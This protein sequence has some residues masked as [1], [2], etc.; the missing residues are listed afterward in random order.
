MAWETISVIKSKQWLIVIFMRN[1]ACFIFIVFV[2]LVSCKKPKDT[3]HPIEYHCLIESFRLVQSNNSPLCEVI[4]NTRGE[5]QL[6][7][8]GLVKYY[9]TFIDGGF[10]EVYESL[11]GDEKKL[12]KK[13]EYKN[14]RINLIRRFGSEPVFGSAQRGVYEFSQ[15]VFHYND[16][17]QPLAIDFLFRSYPEEEFIIQTRY[18]FEYDENGN[19]IYERLLGFN[20]SKQWVTHHARHSY[21]KYPNNMKYLNLLLFASVTFDA[22]RIFSKN[23]R[24]GTVYSYDNTDVTSQ[25]D[26]LITYDSTHNVI[27]DGVNFKDIKWECN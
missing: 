26:G 5:V 24:I 4:Y 19:V 27:S 14:N 20:E 21:D 3:I 17:D 18:E 25:K 1:S 7:N 12:A 22:S 2:L 6:I 15:V 10:V 23:N 11:V 8:L 13:I 16:R 9:Y